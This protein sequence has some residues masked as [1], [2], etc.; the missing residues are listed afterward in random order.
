[1]MLTTRWRSAHTI[2]LLLMALTAITVACSKQSDDDQP[3]PSNT[4]DSQATS[5]LTREE[6]QPL[7]TRAVLQ[8]GD[9]PGAWKAHD[10]GMSNGFA[11]A[12]LGGQQSQLAQ[13]MIEAC[14]APTLEGGGGTTVG[15][16]VVRTLTSD[17]VLGS[18]ISMVARAG[19]GAAQSVQALRQPIGEQTK[20]CVKAEVERIMGGIL[21]SAA[22][23]ISDMR[24]VS[25]LPEGSAANI[26]AVTLG[27]GGSAI[28][29]H[30]VTVGVARD[31]LLSTVVEV[32]FGAGTGLPTPVLA[33]DRLVE[34]ARQRLEE[35]L[36]A[37][38]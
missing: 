17:N 29:Q 34:V 16:G 2:M 6:L 26:L 24:S 36:A 13:A 23:V 27:E 38:R 19:D 8:P 35:A 15:D 12:V 20:A 28:T 33:P 25:G 30:M 37:P 31:G 10:V 14:L 11:I 21:P 9:I 5:S 18:V 22:I 7:L 3:P 4:G 32:T 1:M